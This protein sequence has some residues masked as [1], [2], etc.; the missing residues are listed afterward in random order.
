V[1]K[2]RDGHVTRKKEERSIAAL[3]ERVEELMNHICDAASLPE[4][5]M[6]LLKVLFEACGRLEQ[7]TNEL[8]IRMPIAG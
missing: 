2:I 1:K 4:Q 3:R 6:E 7:F 5:R 8:R